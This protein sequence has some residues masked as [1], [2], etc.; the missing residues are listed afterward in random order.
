M[1]NLISASAISGR[2]CLF[3]SSVPLKRMVLAPKPVVAPKDM[4]TAAEPRANSS[5]MMTSSM[6][7][8]P[9]PPYSSG[10][11]AAKTPRSLIFLP[12]G[13]VNE[14]LLRVFIEV[15]RV[16]P[17]DVLVDELPDVFPQHLLLFRKCKIHSCLHC[18][19]A[20]S[21]A[22]YKSRK[23]S[24]PKSRYLK[25]GGRLLQEGLHAL[26]KTV[27]VRRDACGASLDEEGCIH[28]RSLEPVG[29]GLL[30]QSQGVGRFARDLPGDLQSCLVNLPF[31]TTLFTRP[32]FSASAAPIRSAV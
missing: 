28:A 22:F 29:E 16:F 8:P 20:S 15:P 14:H 19:Q 23:A 7:V 10:T 11:A 31:G 12:H 4:A 32:S 27:A 17:L 5:L 3:C 24:N 25:F 26:L 2:K 9:K 18:L 30:R 1:A 6:M 13:V 21:E